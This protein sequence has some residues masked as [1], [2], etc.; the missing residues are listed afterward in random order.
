LFFK[1]LVIVRR[2]SSDLDFLQQVFSIIVIEATWLELLKKRKWIVSCS[3][4]LLLIFSIIKAVTG[5]LEFY[6]HTFVYSLAIPLFCLAW[7]VSFLKTVEVYSFFL[8]LSIVPLCHYSIGF[9]LDL[10]SYFFQNTGLITSRDYLRLLKD[11]ETTVYFSIAGFFLLFMGLFLDLLCRFRSSRSGFH[12]PKLR[13]NLSV[14]SHRFDSS[15]QAEVI[16][17]SNTIEK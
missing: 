7:L 8:W 5:Q 11:P 17:L 10:F 15:E 14:S 3:A 13:T 1:R 12:L 2:H 16:T 4:I 9:F 6:L